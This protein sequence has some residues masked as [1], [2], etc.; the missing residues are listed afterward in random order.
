MGMYDTFWG[1][2]TRIIWLGVGLG[3]TLLEIAVTITYLSKRL[4]I[5]C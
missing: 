4:E 1:K 2:Y 3:M 5:N